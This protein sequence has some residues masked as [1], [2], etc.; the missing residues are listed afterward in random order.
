M[1]NKGVGMF[2]CSK[3]SLQLTIERMQLDLVQFAKQNVVRPFL[4][5][6]LDEIFVQIRNN[7]QI[8]GLELRGGWLAGWLVMVHWP[9]N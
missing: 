5:H 6:G 7:R 9:K 2:N 8:L 3:M 1:S 4:G